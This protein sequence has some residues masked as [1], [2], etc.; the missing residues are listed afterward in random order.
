VQEHHQ[1]RRAPP[2]GSGQ[3]PTPKSE[4]SQL[5]TA[6]A[7]RDLSGGPLGLSGATTRLC[8]AR[9]SVRHAVAKPSTLHKEPR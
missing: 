4:L 6:A 7:L 8:V 5:D 2:D 9:H 3:T 1:S